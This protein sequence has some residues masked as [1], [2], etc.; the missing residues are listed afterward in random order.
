MPTPTKTFETELV[1][2]SNDLAELLGTADKVTHTIR[3]QDL[4]VLE[5]VSDSIEIARSFHSHGFAQPTPRRLNT[6]VVRMEAARSLPSLLE[7]RIRAC[8]AILVR[9]IAAP[10]LEDET[11][12]TASQRVFSG[13]RISER[14]KDAE[15]AEEDPTAIGLRKHS[16]SLFDRLRHDPEQLLDCTPALLAPT[17]A[18]FERFIVVCRKQIAKA[19]HKELQTESNPTQ[20]VS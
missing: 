8:S 6:Y 1:G 4:A 15:E 9:L 2:F 3:D 11:E 5:G 16:S 12:R 20:A 19:Q 17:K 10:R 7:Q 18:V 14:A 13:F